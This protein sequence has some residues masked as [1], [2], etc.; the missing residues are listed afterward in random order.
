[1]ILLNLVTV[2]NWQEQIVLLDPA[3]ELYGP[4]VVLI[5]QIQEVGEPEISVM[6][7]SNV[8]DVIIFAREVMVR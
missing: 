2:L 3:V 1:M 7:L 5:K 6:L 8:Q 4:I